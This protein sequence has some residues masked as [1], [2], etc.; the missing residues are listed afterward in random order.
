MANYRTAAALLVAVMALATTA[1]AD[2][3]LWLGVK[4]GTLGIGIEGTW[5]PIEWLD[6][7]VGANRYDY[8]D[9]G[10]KAGINYDGTLQL[11]T[12]YG[13][14]N[15]RFPLSPFRISAGYFSNSN[16]VILDSVDSPTFDIGGVSY[17]ASEV[18][19]LTAQADWPSSSPY[20][21]A[22]FDFELF[23]K[24]GLNF[25]FGVL[26]QG[27][28]RVS[29]QSTGSLADDPLFLQAIET[30]RSELEDDISALKAYPVLSM[31]INFNF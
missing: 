8:T 31:G 29:M 21:G 18:G 20:L 28:P 12:Y 4:A 7:R 13:T 5:R 16:K 2:D 30:E 6:L 15:L 19:T 1:D 11:D 23:N 24:V 10:S 17:T 26:W 22:G 9:S 27:D 14:A 3:N 25:D